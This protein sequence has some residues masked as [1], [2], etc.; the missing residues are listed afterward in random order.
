VVVKGEEAGAG[1]ELHPGVAFV[2]GL[3]NCVVCESNNDG[4]GGSVSAYGP[5][6]RRRDFLQ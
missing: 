4:L 1:E 2:P 5:G 3:P 6:K